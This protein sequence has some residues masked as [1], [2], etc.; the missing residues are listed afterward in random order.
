MRILVARAALVFVAACGSSDDATTTYVFGPFHI[1]PSQEIDGSCVQISLNNDDYVNVNAV[2]LTTGTGFHHSNWFYVPPTTFNGPDGTFNCDDRLFDQGVAAIFGGVIFAQSTQA[3]HEVQAFPEGHV[4]R[5][6]PRSK[7]VAQIHLLNPTDRPLDL[8]PNI[9]LTKI[10]DD[11]VTVR[12]AGI[13]FQNAAL[14]LPP[15]MSS[16]F[17]VEC[18]VNQEHVESLKRPIDFKIHYALAHYHELGT[19]LTIEAVKPSGEADIVYTTKTQVGDV[20]GGPIAPAFDMTGY[21]KLRMSCE[22]YNPRSQV[23]GWGIGDQE[24]CVFLAFTDS[25]WNFGGGVLD[26]VPPENEMRVGNTMTYSND[27]FLISN[28]ADRG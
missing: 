24:M 28:D 27:C 20:M 15:N 8:E 3:P 26:E 6:P 22:F 5:V 21:Q 7:L 10:P 25:T 19:G 1:E 12:L 11:E 17:S 16:K 18:D 9:K 14:A 13:S 23:V 4:V 2:E